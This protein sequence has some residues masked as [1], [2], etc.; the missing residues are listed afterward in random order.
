MAPA[1]GERVVSDEAEFMS[2]AGDLPVRASTGAG[3]A[4]VLPRT[5]T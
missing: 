5:V 2:H 4:G 1:E 3:G